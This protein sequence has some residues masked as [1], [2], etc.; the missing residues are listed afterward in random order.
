MIKAE[1][2]NEAFCIFTEVLLDALEG[3]AKEA[4]DPSTEGELVVTSGSLT[5]YIEAQV[6]LAAG[7]HHLTMS[8]LPQPGFFT[9][10]TYVRF[11][12][13][14]LADRETKPGAGRSTPR[15]AFAQ[16][17]ESES[18]II[19]N[20]RLEKLRSDKE[21]KAKN[22]KVELARSEV[23]T[24]FET[25]C[26]L[27]VAGALVKSITETKGTETKGWI[28]ADDTHPGWF[29]VNVGGAYPGR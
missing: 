26:G 28:E 20:T 24:H 8:P 12:S 19:E 27:S 21:Q 23:P 5:S 29:R 11:P 6:P 9:D 16:T 18:I 10:T 3:D 2:S 15:A 14:W 1:G 22:I 13:G 25:G 4:F 7:R 17:P